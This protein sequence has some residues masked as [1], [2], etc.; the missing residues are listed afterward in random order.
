M[1]VT[2]RFGKA[3]LWCYLRT[4]KR[5]VCGRHKVF[6]SLKA[7]FTWLI[8]QVVTAD[9]CTTAAFVGIFVVLLRYVAASGANVVPSHPS[10]STLRQLRRVLTLESFGAYVGG[11]LSS[12]LRGVRCDALWEVFSPLG[13]VH[14][15]AALNLPVIDTVVGHVNVHTDCNLISCY[16]SLYRAS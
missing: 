1:L 16:A 7:S 10:C 6:G 3:F 14:F 15:F 5:K 13:G 8:P 4:K 2:I 9:M 12:K 11:I